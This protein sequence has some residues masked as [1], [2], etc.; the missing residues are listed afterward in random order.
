MFGVVIVGTALLIDV[1]AMLTLHR[2]KTT[3]LPNRGAQKLVTS[4]P[5]SFSRNPIYLA[6]VLLMFGVGM[7]VGNLWFWFLAIPVGGLTQHLAIKREEAHLQ[8]KFP[9]GWLAYRKKVRRWI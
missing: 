5:F 1:F 3:V 4:G 7:A 2:A 6:N 9:A 8:M